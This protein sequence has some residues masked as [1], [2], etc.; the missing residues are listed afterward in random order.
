MDEEY[1]LTRAS[2]FHGG[3]EA[4]YCYYV[5]IQFLITGIYFAQA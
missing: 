2:I 4:T 5:G 3:I 1:F